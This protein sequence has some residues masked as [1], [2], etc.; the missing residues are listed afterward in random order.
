MPTLATR[1]DP[2]WTGLLLAG[3]RSRRMGRDK[4]GLVWNG[5][6]LL[7][8]QSQRLADAGARRVLVSGD[9][10]QH[11]S[12]PDLRPE[13]GPLGGLQAVA[14]QIEDGP[15][16]V[17]AIDMPQ[18]T[19]ELLATL[20]RTPARSAHYRGHILPLRI[21]LDPAL[22]AWLRDSH[23]RP[24]AERSLRALFAECGGIILPLPEDGERLLANCNTPEEW[25][26]LAP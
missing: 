11:Q 17:L 24:P 4:A 7:E 9:Y 12:V 3:G 18:V 14:E 21:E 13:Q 19:P 16:V 5:R 23:R 8:L 26:A 10:P 1:T 25:E 6:T 15:L 20:A 2:P 22:R